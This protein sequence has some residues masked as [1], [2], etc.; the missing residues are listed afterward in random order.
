MGLLEFFLRENGFNEPITGI[1]HDARKILTANEIGRAYASL[2]FRTVD[3][4]DPMQRGC[5]VAL[6]DVLHYFSDDDQ[7]RILDNAVAAVPPGGIVIIRDA[8]RDKSFR[9]RITKAQEMFSRAIR[10]LRAERLN[11]P[12]HAQIVAPFRGFSEEVKPMWGGTP[13]NNYLFVFKRSIDG[14]TN[15]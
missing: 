13:F 15:R 6:I 9:Y 5:N 1:D 2:Q 12:T 3:A 14:I 7:R 4:R 8:I 11:F 10:W